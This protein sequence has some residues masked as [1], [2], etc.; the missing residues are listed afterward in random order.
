MYLNAGVCIRL[1]SWS[2]LIANLSNNRTG[3]NQSSE[4]ER[5][6]RA[7]ITVV[8]AGSAPSALHPKAV[9]ATNGTLTVSNTDMLEYRG[10]SRLSPL[11]G[12][13]HYSTFEL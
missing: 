13:I 7:A 2:I 3:T 1:E 10:R 9:I 4:Y 11:H 5:V 8:S 6:V 12:T